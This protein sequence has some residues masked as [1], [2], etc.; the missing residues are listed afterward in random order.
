MSAT[1]AIDALIRA[2]EKFHTAGA[3]QLAQQPLSLDEHPLPSL[4]RMGALVRQA[5]LVPEQIRTS[6]RAKAARQG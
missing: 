6:G 5:I 2:V 1:Q 3:M 4:S